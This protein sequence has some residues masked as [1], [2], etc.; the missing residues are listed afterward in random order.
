M[1]LLHYDRMTGKPKISFLNCLFED[2]DI[3]GKVEMVADMRAW[4]H[5]CSVS[6][7]GVLVRP[8]RRLF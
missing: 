2:I 8:S 7:D 1:Q 6:L 4:R 5:H 3:I